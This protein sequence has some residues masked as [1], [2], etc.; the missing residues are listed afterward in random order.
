MKI[1]FKTQSHFGEY[2][3]NGGG[4]KAP[5]PKNGKKI[6]W[7]PPEGFF[8]FLFHSLFGLKSPFLMC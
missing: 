1:K 4:K 6:F 5:K 3:K 8:F 2:N 7:E